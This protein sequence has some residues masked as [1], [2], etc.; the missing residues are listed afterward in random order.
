MQNITY[1]LYKIEWYKKYEYFLSKWKG[2]KK[3]KIIKI[4]F[5]TRNV[6]VIKSKV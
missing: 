2:K 1:R 6:D 4:D 3:V 5:L